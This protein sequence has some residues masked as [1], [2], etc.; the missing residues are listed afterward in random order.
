M[1]NF[2]EIMD[3]IETH[4]DEIPVRDTVDGK[5]GS[6]FLSELPVKLALR[7]AF[8]WIQ[9]GTLPYRVTGRAQEKP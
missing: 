4:A 7:W 9:L 2:V 6:Y 8:R 1:T 5:A 3:Y